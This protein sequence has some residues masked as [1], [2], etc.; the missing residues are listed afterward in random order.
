M[1]IIHGIH[2]VL[3]NALVCLCVLVD[4]KHL[5][6]QVGRKFYELE[7]PEKKTTNRR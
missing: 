2:F 4:R 1:I 7:P 3:E 5:S 6:V